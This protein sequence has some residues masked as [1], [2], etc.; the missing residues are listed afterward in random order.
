[1]LQKLYA[2][3]LTLNNGGKDMKRAALLAVAIIMASC[4][5]T[6]S[7]ESESC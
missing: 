2:S 5:S 1:M 4:A 6:H 3:G 7:T